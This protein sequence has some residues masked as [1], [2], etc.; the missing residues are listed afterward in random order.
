VN[1]FVGPDALWQLHDDAR[2]EGVSF[3]LEPRCDRFRGAHSG[4]RRLPSP[5]RV[6][7]EIVLATG[8][9]FVAVADTLEGT[10]RHHATWRFP[11]EPGLDAVIDRGDV[12]LSKDDDER[13]VLALGEP[14][15]MRWT[16]EPGWVSPSYGVRHETSV[17]TLRGELQLPSRMTYLFATRRRSDAARLADARSVGLEVN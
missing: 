14:G 8:R 5:V 7:R 13:W 1:R 3:R 10:G 9:S 6:Q 15:A 16:L 2:P 12:R 4:Y 17:L 11:L